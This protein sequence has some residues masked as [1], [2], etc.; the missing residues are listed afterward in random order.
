MKCLLEYKN[1]FTYL[2]AQEPK[3]CIHYD[4][5]QL[6]HSRKWKNSM[7]EKAATI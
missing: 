5:V 2:S 1:K 6:T 4:A 7:N 3:K